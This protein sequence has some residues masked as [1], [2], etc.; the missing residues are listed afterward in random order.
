MK[1]EKKWKKSRGKKQQI[2]TKKKQAVA[3][4]CQ[5]QVNFKL[6]SDF[7]KIVLSRIKMSKYL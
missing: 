7:W 4:M 1:M 5:A 6:D 3:E 2:K